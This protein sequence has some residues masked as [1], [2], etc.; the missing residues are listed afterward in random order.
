M[1]KI[2]IVVIVGIMIIAC[3][4]SYRKNKIVETELVIESVIDTVKNN[5][6]N[7]K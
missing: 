2:L 1:K 3:K 5:N 7:Q 6:C 4:I